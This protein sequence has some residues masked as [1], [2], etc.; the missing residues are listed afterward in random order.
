MPYAGA[1]ALIRFGTCCVACSDKHR[2]TKA[3]THTSTAFGSGTAGANAE[4]S[5]KATEVQNASNYIQWGHAF[6]QPT[7][8]GPGYFTLQY[9]LFYSIVNCFT[10]EH[11]AIRRQ[12]RMHQAWHSVKSFYPNYCVGHPEIYLFLLSKKMILGS[13]YPK[14]CLFNFEKNF[15]GGIH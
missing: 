5:L 1:K 14:N 6:C 15:T 10:T 2:F 13:K 11:C 3:T 7:L 9:K 12:A 8:S 4:I